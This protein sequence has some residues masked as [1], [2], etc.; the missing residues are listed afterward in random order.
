MARV[1]AETPGDVS[2]IKAA[3]QDE[4]DCGREQYQENVHDPLLSG[5]A[6]PLRTSL[7]NTARPMCQNAI[8]GHVLLRE[9][10]C[11]SPFFIQIFP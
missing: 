2:G 10:R 9:K 1:L 3:G 6:A 4:N 11:V 7:N 8:W 5:A